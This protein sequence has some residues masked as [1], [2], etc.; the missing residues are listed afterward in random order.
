[1]STMGAAASA[2]GSGLAERQQAILAMEVLG[3]LPDRVRRAFVLVRFEGQSYRDVAQRLGV[4]VSTV[5]MDIA[6][7]LRSLSQRLPL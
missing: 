2:A 1:M 6:L 3:A 7:A 5:E 4:Q